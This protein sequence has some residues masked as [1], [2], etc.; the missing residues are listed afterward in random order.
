MVAA[1]VVFALLFVGSLG[2]AGTRAEVAEELKLFAL[3]E[4]FGFPLG[5]F[6]T[7]LFWIVA[8]SYF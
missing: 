3:I 7:L 2:S 6:V 4:L 1:F 8:F 5:E